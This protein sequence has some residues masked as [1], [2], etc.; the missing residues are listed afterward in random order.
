MKL[1][2]TGARVR[3]AGVVLLAWAL[4]A[5]TAWTQSAP[6]R[7]LLVPFCTDSAPYVALAGTPRDVFLSCIETGAD[8]TSGY[9]SWNF[10]LYI[11]RQLQLRGFEVVDPWHTEEERN[12]MREVARADSVL[13]ARELTRRFTVDVVSLLWYEVD[14][15]VT[16]DGYC[17]ATATVEVE[18]Y[19]GAARDIDAGLGRRFRMTRRECMH[20]IISVEKST[21]DGVVH[22]LTAWAEGVVARRHPPR[23]P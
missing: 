18:G 16:N 1:K 22:V 12:R 19:D 5:E 11:K 21:G 14:L 9:R 10:Y 15:W 3:L 13:A 20:A 2:S 8:A 23:H 7:I 6:I 4:L 17:Q